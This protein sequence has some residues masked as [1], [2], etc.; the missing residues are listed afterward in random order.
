MYSHFGT[1]EETKCSYDC[2]SCNDIK[3]VGR[4]K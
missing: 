1:K 3:C 4:T 2:I